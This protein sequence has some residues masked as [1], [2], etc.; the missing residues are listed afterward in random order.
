MLLFCLL[1]SSVRAFARS[2]GVLSK[3]WAV[4]AALQKP[5]LRCCLGVLSLVAR[6]VESLEG[7]IVIKRQV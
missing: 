3:S 4:S 2:G 7:V 1:G 6:W 5:P